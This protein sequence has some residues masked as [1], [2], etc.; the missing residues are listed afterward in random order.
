MVGTKGSVDSLRLIVI[1][2]GDARVPC[3]FNWETATEGGEYTDKFYTIC[4]FTGNC[5][6]EAVPPM[7]LYNEGLGEFVS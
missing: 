7:L 6:F 2:K 1:A 5:I 3:T 4:C